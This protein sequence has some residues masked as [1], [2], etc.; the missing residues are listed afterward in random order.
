MYNPQNNNNTIYY[1][2]TVPSNNFELVPNSAFNNQNVLA[3]PVP[4]SPTTPVNFTNTNN[5]KNISYLDIP[6]LP[7][8][9]I[10]SKN[11][12]NIDTS[13]LAPSTPSPKIHT[14][15]PNNTVSAGTVVVPYDVPKPSS[16]VTINNETI[17]SDF[18]Q[19]QNI[20]VQTSDKLNYPYITNLELPSV[21]LPFIN[22]INAQLVLP[23]INTFDMES[24][25]VMEVFKNVDINRVAASKSHRIKSTKYDKNMGSYSIKYI[26]EIASKLGIPINSSKESIVNAIHEYYRRYIENKGR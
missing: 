3:S 26:M 2:T 14:I 1:N 13:N 8:L 15:V 24:S 25:Q 9:N 5:V 10:Y 17:W 4:F 21:D 16:I 20:Q 23:Q 12:L 11:E 19:P 6:D 7:R 22:T 18:M